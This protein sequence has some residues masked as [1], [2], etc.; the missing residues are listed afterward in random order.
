M[1]RALLLS[2]L[3]LLGTLSWSQASPA[4]YQV[5]GG[6]SYV[7]SNFAWLGGGEN[8]WN[9]AFDVNSQKW[10]GFTADFAQYYATYS[11]GGCCP[12]DHSNTS[13]FLFGPRVSAPLS[14]APKLTPFGHF[15]LGVAHINYKAANISGN[16]FS[17]STS[18]AWAFG[19]GLDYRLANHFSLR[20][21]GD[22]MHSHF[23][24]ADNQLQSRVPNWHGRI[25]T[26]VVF[27]F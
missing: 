17:T 27:R 8:G 24:T 20:G 23:V 21:E 26:G 25:S 22:Y 2:L 1:A 4:R 5:Y 7:P 9:A 3:L 14:K 10:L 13:T 19:G 11:F 12:A 16:F 18:F 6:Y 15:L